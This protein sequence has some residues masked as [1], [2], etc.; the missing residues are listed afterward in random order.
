MELQERTRNCAVSEVRFKRLEDDIVELKTKTKDVPVVEELLR[1]MIGVN[2]EQNNIMNKNSD[3]I[4][5]INKTLIKVDG[6]MDTMAKNQSTFS[7]NLDE[8][9][10]DIND[11]KEERNVNIIKSIKD[12]WWK[13]VLAGIG[14]Y[15]LAQAVLPLL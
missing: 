6:N 3:A 10:K 1:Q 4:I 9:K 11:L 14:L 13:I 15:E 12:N 2:K 7:V 5:D 8:V